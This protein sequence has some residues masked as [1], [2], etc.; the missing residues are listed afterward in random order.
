MSDNAKLDFYLQ[1]RLQIE[2]WAALRTE[3]QQ[4]LDDELLR[5]IAAIDVEDSTMKINTSNPRTVH[6]HL[7]AARRNVW[8]ELNWR[9]SALLTGPGLTAWPQIILVIRPGSLDPATRSAIIDATA[10]L[11]ISDGMGQLGRAN[12]WWARWGS[13]TPHAE[14]IDIHTYA[15][16]CALRFKEVWV[17]TR[18]DTAA[19]LGR[20]RPRPIEG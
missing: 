11:A 1:H 20:E 18:K 15:Q 17:R 7:P 4:R 8:V 5:A 2:E 14:P 9:K 13:L 16:Y 19:L 6:F 3:A 10:D 12:D